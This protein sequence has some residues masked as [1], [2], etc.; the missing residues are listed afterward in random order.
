M[1]VKYIKLKKIAT[2]PTGKLNSNAA[3]KD[4]I[5]PFFTCSHDIYRI[6][7][8]AYDGE[9]VLLGGNNATGDFP[10]FYY[11]GKFNAY[12]RTYLIQPIDTNQFDTRYLFYSIGL[13]LKLMQSNAAGTATRFL[14]QPI[15]D[16][17][18]IEYRPLPIQQ[19]IAS[20]LSAY[21]NLIQNYKKQIEALQTGTCELYKE[22]FVRFRFPGWQNAKFENGIPE[23]WKVEKLFDVA[24]IIY[25]YPFNSD[26]FC[27]DNSL[28]PVVR[29]RDI[30]DNHT[31][32]YTS[33]FCDEKYWIN[34]NEML[35]GMDGIFH[36][37]LWTGERALQNQRTVRVTSKIKNL[38]NYYLYFSL[39]PQ[40]KALEQ[41]IVGTTVAHLG[42]KHL[43]KIAILVPEDKIL[44]MSYE[45][46]EPMMNRIYS[47]QQQITNLTQQ[48]DLLLPR[49][50]SDKLEVLK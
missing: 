34:P 24:K 31:D 14:T 8:Y 23:G 35:I 50:M 6:N 30:L 29:I 18:N 33:E 37:T 5:Y 17:I 9:Y 42:D 45:R 49:L 4:G 19:K 20:I 3:E 1:K 12:Q 10:I 38:S 47:L 36:M 7:N 13:K 27:D 11:N 41:M 40:I 28:N 2:Y 48:R 46:F 44:K 16:N 22:W 15:L 25:G 43:K 39:Y 26:E 32:T 21:D